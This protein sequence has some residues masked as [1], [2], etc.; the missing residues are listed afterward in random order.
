MLDPLGT[1][2][3][4]PGDQHDDDL[5][6]LYFDTSPLDEPLELA[7][8]PAAVL[9]LQSVE[10][11]D[12]RL[13]VKFCDVDEHGLSQLLTTG[14][15]RVADQLGD[16]S[17]ATVTVAAGPVA[18]VIAAGHRLRVSISSVD[19][20]RAWPTPGP[21]GFAVSLGGEGGSRFILPVVADIASGSAH[22]A[23]VPRPPGGPR[24]D[25]VNSGTVRYR[26]T[27]Q[28]PDGVFEAVLLN[29][30]EL[31]PPSGAVMRLD[32]RFTARL[33]Q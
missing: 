1:G 6:S 3:G 27:Q 18:A 10:T 28:E 4:H 20:P 24:P 19:F 33:G 23:E 22:I 29:N 9:N 15:L 8:N 16:G 17:S 32:E 7:G 31:A 14:W 2:F 30:A 21:A 13:A 12:L 25:W 26:R 5:A 11:P